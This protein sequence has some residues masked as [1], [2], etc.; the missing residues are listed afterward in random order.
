MAFSLV[1]FD[2]E[3]G[4]SPVDE[5]EM[6]EYLSLDFVEFTRTRTSEG[7]LNVT[8]SPLPYHEC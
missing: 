4:Y 5:T 1:E 2:G 7:K 3:G 8:F 6:N